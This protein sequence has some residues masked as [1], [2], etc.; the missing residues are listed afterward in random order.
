MFQTL[1]VILPPDMLVIKMNILI[2]QDGHACLADFGLL[3]IISES[4]LHTASS[5]SE[6]AGTTRW[7]SPELL[8]PDKFGFKNGQLTKES[9]CYALGMVVLEVLTSKPPFPYYTG[10]VV[11]RK[12]VD[13]EQPTRPQGTKGVWFTDSLWGTL[14]QCWSPQPGDRPTAEAVLE[15]L[16]QVSVAWQPLPPDVDSDAEADSDEESFLMTS[17]PGMFLHLIASPD[18]SQGD[19]PI[20]GLS[21]QRSPDMATVG[22]VGVIKASPPFQA[23]PSH[24]LE[25]L[26]P[27]E[28]AQITNKV[29]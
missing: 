7:M 12:V 26:G 21:I 28:S 19:P 8:D 2:D 27:E 22:S 14:R 15:C 6:G 9:D 24:L 25:K 17:G 3:T 16:E 4:T 23:A 18:S 20:A 5:S 10:L 11:M 29:S 1:V 13:G